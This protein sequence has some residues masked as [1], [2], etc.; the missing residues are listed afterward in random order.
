MYINISINNDVFHSSFQIGTFL[1][2][3]LVI[4]AKIAS[5][6]I[7]RYDE[8]EQSCL[9]P[10]FSGIALIFSPFKLT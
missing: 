2:P 1:F 4:L 7:N 6:I 3:S 10:Y 5:T 9:I 8:R